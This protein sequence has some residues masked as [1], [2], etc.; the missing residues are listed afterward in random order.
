MRKPAIKLIYNG[1]DISGLLGEWVTSLEYI[2]HK[3]GKSDEVAVTVHNKT[4]QW[5]EEWAPKDGDTFTLDFGYE[6]EMIPA[7]EFT[8]DDDGADGDADGDTV[9]FKGLS[10]PSTKELRTRKSK[11]YENQSLCQIIEKIAGEHGFS[12]TGDIEDISFERVTQNGERDLEFIKRLS[13]DYGHYFSV[14]GKKLVFTSRDALRSRDQVRIIDRIENVA[15]Q[16]LKRYSM[17]NRDYKAATEAKVSYHHPKKKKVI[18]GEASSEGDLGIMTSSGDIIKTEIR[19][20]NE[21]QAK[22][23]AKGRLDQRNADKISGDL[24]LV[25]DPTLVAGQIVELK[26]FGKFSGRYVIA[27]SKHTFQRSGYET[28]ITLEQ[29]T[30][31]QQAAGKKIRQNSG[32]GSGSGSS[33][34]GANDLGVMGN[35]GVIRK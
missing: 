1:R 10:T 12:V 16:L 9:N 22:R 24:E 28:G 19:V 27:R 15:E 3:H 33:G 35:D 14:K 21:E 11:A 26:N 20:E 32:G 23:V 5:L 13:E 34:S 25:G 30:D 18:K 2:D 6:D 17:R 4:G 7:G 8:V 29:V 31:K